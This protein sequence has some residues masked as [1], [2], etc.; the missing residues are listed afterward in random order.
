MK[1][2]KLFPGL[3]PA[4][5]AGCA[6]LPPRGPEPLDEAGRYLD[7]ALAE[8]PVPHRPPAA[9]EAALLPGFTAD[10]RSE[11]LATQRF[12]VSVHA[13][14]AREFFMGLVEGTPYN[15][16]V[17]PDVSGTITLNLKDVSI[18]AVMDIA[19]NVYG[20]E[21]ERTPYGYQV[22]PARIRSRIYQVNF[23]NVLR[24]G[25]SQTRVSSGQVSQTNLDNGN[26]AGSSSERGTDTVTGTEINTLQPET[27]FW[28][29]LQ[30]SVQAILGDAPGRS[31]VVN[32]QSGV[33]VVRAMPQELR[34]VEDFLRTTEAV[35]S[36]QVVLE[37]KILE[38]ELD[39][40]FRAGINWSAISNQGNRTIVASQ[41]GGG[42]ELNGVSRGGAS[43]S[44]GDF[45]LGSAAFDTAIGT[46]AAAFGG[47]FSL[48]LSLND[49]TAFIELLKTQGN[50]QVLS[51][52]R[53]STLNN[54]KAV[55]K[56]GTDEFFVTDISNT[57]VTGTTTTTTPLVELTPFFSGIALDVTPQIS[58]QGD[59]LLHV[60]PSVSEVQDQ[61]KTINV[62]GVNQ[63]LPLALSTVRESDSVVRARSGQVVV[64]GGLMRNQWSDREAAPPGL[65][66][67]LGH[68]EKT[69][70]KTELVILLRPLVVDEETTWQDLLGTQHEQL[71]AMRH[72]GARTE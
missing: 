40:G 14:P 43:P 53:V 69:A 41:V 52:P 65:G 51:S 30:S 49:F 44:T 59:V 20:Y 24:S 1:L 33:V 15:M 67:V 2:C 50:V 71:G 31:V 21:Y 25:T 60:H 4:M 61:A 55:I 70:R 57:T 38:V 37:A 12:D 48:A 66:G 13:A 27:S 46:S 72:Y 56:V 36:R 7:R 62:G 3:L 8:R 64:I 22:L 63:S 32:P 23:L 17:H 18:P 5:L 47:V 45:S 58:E 28:S 35:A 6:D 19:R 9:V 39:D 68:R 10:A 16:V 34:E 54:Q 26:D 11:K 29:E 42:T